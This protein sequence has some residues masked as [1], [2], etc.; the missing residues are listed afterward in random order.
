MLAFMGILGY[1]VTGLIVGGLG[2]FL[3][4]WAMLNDRLNG[5]HKK[6]RCPRCWYDMTGSPG[7]RCSECGHEAR[8]E[9][10]LFR[11]RKR[12]RTATVGLV[13]LLAGVTLMVWPDLQSGR[14]FEL[15]PR[16][17][18]VRVWPLGGPPFFPGQLLREA[19]LNNSAIQDGA[20]FDMAIRGI[21]LTVGEPGRSFCFEILTKLGRFNDESRQ[22]AT[23]SLRAGVWAE[24]QV[25]VQHFELAVP[26]RQELLQAYR[27]ELSRS[28]APNGRLLV[29]AVMKLAPTDD[30]ARDLLLDVALDP[31]AP[32]NAEAVAV[33][34]RLG[35]LMAPQLLKRLMENAS[36]D[37]IKMV[38]VSMWPWVNSSVSRPPDWTLWAWRHFELLGSNMTADL[39]KDLLL[40]DQVLNLEVVLSEAF[41]HPDDPRRELAMAVAKYRQ[42]YLPAMVDL[43]FTQ[44][45]EASSPPAREVWKVLG[46]CDASRRGDYFRLASH[47][48]WRFRRAWCQSVPGAH[49]DLREDAVEILRRLE[50]QHAQTEEVR[51]A[52]RDALRSFGLWTE[53]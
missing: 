33:I 44:V 46:H 7:L 18:Q 2:S 50:S 29:E 34:H 10:R 40:A 25:A 24:A 26:N 16:W 51:V 41:Q 30:A 12:W 17:A 49:T 9:S 31:S 42:I 45:K 11:S 47:H 23:V 15:L 38:D 4:W 6:R 48:D 14:W 27:A 43:A 32:A 22:A 20:V 21:N 8:V 1:L 28:G 13:G 39:R 53:K 3:L 37:V 36:P 52:A 19:R 35:P 5:G